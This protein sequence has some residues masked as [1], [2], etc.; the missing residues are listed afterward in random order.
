MTSITELISKI[1]EKQ[2]EFN[3]KPGDLDQGIRMGLEFATNILQTAAADPDGAFPITSVC[4]EDLR[5]REGIDEQVLNVVTADEMEYLASKMADD[6][7][8]QMFW[9]SM[10]SIY[11]YRIVPNAT[12][13][14]QGE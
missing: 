3:D 8:E 11:N 12:K 14:L 1:R 9:G 4:K 2:K 13:R 10:E 6:Y 7:C 5:G